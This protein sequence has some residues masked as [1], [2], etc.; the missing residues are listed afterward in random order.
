MKFC[1]S[2]QQCEHIH[3]VLTLYIANDFLEQ[4][5]FSK[6]VHCASRFGFLRVET[7]SFDEMQQGQL[8]GFLYLSVNSILRPDVYE[9]TMLQL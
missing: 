3:L 2:H 5:D 6:I 4:Y 1:I 7:C 9:P 8:Y